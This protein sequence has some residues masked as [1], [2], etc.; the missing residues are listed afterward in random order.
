MGDLSRA[1]EVANMAVNSMPQDHPD[2]A[3]LLSTLGTSLGRR[4]E[5]TGSIDDLNR[6][7]E[8]ADTAVKSTP[9]GH[10]NRAALFK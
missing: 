5:R 3:K 2:R 6:A 8:V 7:V 4:F 9:D 1:V 10:S